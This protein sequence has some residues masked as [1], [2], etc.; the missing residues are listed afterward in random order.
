VPTDPLGLAEQTLLGRYYIEASIAQGGMGVVYRGCDL[1]LRRPVCIKIFHRASGSDLVYRASYEHFVQEAFALSRLS[2]P[3]TLRIYDFG[4][5]MDDSMAPFQVSE[6]LDGGTL[7]QWIREQGP[8]SPLETLGLIGPVAGALSEAHSRGIIHRDVKPSNIILGLLGSRRVAKLG[9]FGIA[10]TTPEPSHARTSS[11]GPPS[12]ATMRLYSVGW[13]APEQLR[14]ESATPATD[15]FALGLV[16]AFVLGGA[17]V[18]STRNE[19]AG[20]RERAHSDAYV[21]RRLE[22]L[23]LLP[24]LAEVVQ[25]ACRAAPDERYA[26][27]DLFA[28]ALSEAVDLVTRGGSQRPASMAAGTSTSGS[29][30]EA[31]ASTS[32]SRA[33]ARAST[34]GSRAEARASTE[35]EDSESGVTCSSLLLPADEGARS[36]PLLLPVESRSPRTSSHLAI[37]SPALA[38]ARERKTGRERAPKQLVDCDG[39]REITVLDRR[40]MLVDLGVVGQ[41]DLGGE[42]APL[43]SKARF[44]ITLLPSRLRAASINVK[45]L[46][47]FVARLAGRPAAAINVDHDTEL[48]LLAADRLRLEGVRCAIGR[49]VDGQHLY[50]LGPLTL[51]VTGAPAGAVLLDLGPG[52]EFVL[53]HR[54]VSALRSGGSL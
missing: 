51:A 15:V 8:R 42:A 41:L 46:N 36:S 45:G 1:R 7:A 3:N 31:R 13:G 40:L 21:A 27:A 25:V 4:H 24:E 12:S 9:D 49:A 54:G 23:A 33:E 50:D 47:C 38:R 37:P 22:E 14:G 35:W 10:K 29:R 30:A 11:D 52:R 5:L 6:L 43:R 34:S 26:S 19:A 39:D 28:S 18:F 32:G 16:T 17:S 53:I 44:R 2:H 48:E 20:A